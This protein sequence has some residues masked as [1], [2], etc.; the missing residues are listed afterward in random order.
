MSVL[1]HACSYKV[2]AKDISPYLQGNFAAP[3]PS[4]VGA[5]YFHLKPLVLRH[6]D[7]SEV[8]FLDADNIPTRDPSFLFEDA[9]YKSSGA[10]FWPDY[11]KTA[12]KN[13][14]FDIFPKLNNNDWEHESGQMV[15]IKH[16]AIS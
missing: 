8:L 12:P 5:K 16:K 4:N 1:K 11:W 10:I 13:P 14:I 9:R 7:L 3:L 15:T 6:T 2:E